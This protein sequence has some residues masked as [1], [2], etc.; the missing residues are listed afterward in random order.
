MNSEDLTYRQATLNASYS[1]T[2]LSPPFTGKMLETNTP[3][4]GIAIQ[5]ESNPIVKEAHKNAI[6]EIL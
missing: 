1:G 4:V 2:L 5:G 6:R 3:V